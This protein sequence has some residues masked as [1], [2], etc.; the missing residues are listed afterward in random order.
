[1][2]LPALPLIIPLIAAIALMMTLNSAKAQ[3]W[4]SGAAALSM[5]AISV[6]LLT[7][8]HSQG[9]VALQLGGW[10]APF[11]ISIVL[12]MLSM[13]MLTA[14]SCVAVVVIL[15]SYG[16]IDKSK[17][18]IGYYPLVFCLLTGVNGAFIT[19]DIFNLYVWYEVMLTASFVL[20]TL[21]KEREQLSAG[22]KYLTIN[23]A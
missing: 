12:D 15:Y 20:M 10:K 23:F 9:I 17:E 13:I 4:I 18:R 1:M 5:L 22:I 11:G 8:V 3:K 16:S 19:G 21:G 6:Y 7:N 14:T 2:I